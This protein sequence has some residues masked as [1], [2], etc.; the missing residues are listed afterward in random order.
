MADECCGPD[1]AASGDQTAPAEL[2]PVWRIRELQAAALAGLLLLAGLIA[3][4][5]SVVETVLFWAAAVVGGATFVPGALR[6]LMKGRLGVGLLM[7]IAAVGAVLLGEIAEAAMLAFLFSIAEGLEGYALTRTRNSLRALL[8]LVPPTATVLRNGTPTTVGLAELRVGDTLL[9]RPGDKVATDGVV[10]SGRTAIDTSVVTG[11]S[12]DHGMLGAHYESMR[13]EHDVL[14]QVPMIANSPC[15]PCAIRK[16]RTC[17]RT[18]AP[19]SPHATTP[20]LP[21]P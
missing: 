14:L 10:I 13:S 1:E 15:N 4:A 5:G 19:P 7:T 9:V 16:Y 8:D 11:E 3:P 17:A 18:Q 2:T 12:V 6:G 21:G 20:T